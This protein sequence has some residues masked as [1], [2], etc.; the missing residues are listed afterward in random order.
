MTDTIPRCTITVTMNDE[1]KLDAHVHNEELP[2]E[3]LIDALH[4]IWLSAEQRI[5]QIMTEA[6]G[7]IYDEF[8]QPRH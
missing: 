3:E 5:D 7:Q 2:T 6:M 1:G 8:Q 4:V